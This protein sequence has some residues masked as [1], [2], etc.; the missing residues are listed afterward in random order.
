MISIIFLFVI[1]I[2]CEKW[3][4]RQTGYD[5]EDHDHGYAGA[6][7]TKAIDFYLCGKRKFQVHYYGDDKLNW[8]KNFSNCDP[9]GIGKPIDG[10]CIYSENSYK[11]RLYR[12]QNWLGTLKG[13]DIFDDDFG[14]IGELGAPLACLAIFGGDEYRIGYLSDTEVIKSSNEKFVADRIILNLFG[15]IVKNELEYEIEKKLDL[16]NENKL[17]DVSA[18]L[19]YN[20]EININGNE[21]KIIFAKE[22]VVFRDWKGEINNYLNIQLKKILNFDINE[23]RKKFELLISEQLM[24][25]VMTISSFLKEGKIKIE[26][27]SKAADDFISF[28]GGCIFNLFIKSNIKLLDIIKKVIKLLT[29][30]SN[31]DEKKIILNKLK[32]LNEFK[33]IDDIAILMTHNYYIIIQIILL[34]ILKN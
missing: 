3:W 33:D 30:Y 28:R 10:I 25:G 4:S 20:N 12:G 14:Y 18:K 15:D 8:S 1:Q 24:N 9:V 5:I 34:Y 22:K 16:G 23:E 7:F 21:I 31:I 27:A 13:C 6:S 17:Y 26:L 32:Y 11:G 2:N 19:T 29:N